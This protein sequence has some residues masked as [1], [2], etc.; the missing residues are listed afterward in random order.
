MV[1]LKNKT[2]EAEIA[3]NAVIMYIT[4]IQTPTS[5]LNLPEIITAY[6]AEI[7]KRSICNTLM[8][9]VKQWISEYP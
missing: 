9:I 7:N 8:D 3:K 1:A 5:L 6:T 2:N 4:S